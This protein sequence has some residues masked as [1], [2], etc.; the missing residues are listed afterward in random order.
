MLR[1]L[2]SS[3][4]RSWPC[5]RPISS[6][7]SSR[8]ASSS[9]PPPSCSWPRR[10]CTRA[11][12]GSIA[13]FGA[14]GFLLRRRARLPEGDGHGRR[15][16][17]APARRHARADVAGRADDRH[18]RGPRS[19]DRPVARHGV[20]GA[21]DGH[22]VRAVPGARARSSPCS[23]GIALLDAYLSIAATAA[24]ARRA[25]CRYLVRGIDGPRRA[26]PQF[27]QPGE[28]RLALPQLSAAGSELRRQRHGRARRRPVAATGLSRPTGSRRSAAARPRRGSFAQALVDEGLATGDGRRAPARRAPPPAVRRARRRRASTRRPPSSCRCTCSS[29]R[30][31][32]PYALRDGRPARRD[33]RPDE[34]PR[35]R[36]AAAR[37]APSGR[38]RRRGRDEIVERAPQARPRVRGVRPARARRRAGARRRGRGGRRDRP[39]GRRRRLGGAARPASSTRSSSRRPRTAPRTSTSS[40][41]RTRSSSASAS[42]A[43]CRRCSASRSG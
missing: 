11:S 40:R 38:V 8:I 37:D 35:D 10:R 43:C 9:P 26:P 14:S 7:G 12:S 3:A 22:P 32:L 29:A 23:P 39:R 15:Q 21:E 6:T 17:R 34:R 28:T 20:R 16:A 25:R 4:P 18:V 36:R 19:L 41:R 5:P 33:R 2:R 31:A 30:R 24:K 1:S 27:R 42:T 13:G